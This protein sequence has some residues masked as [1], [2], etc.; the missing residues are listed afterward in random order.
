MGNIAVKPRASSSRR[1][2]RLPPPANYPIL[3]GTLGGLVLRPWFDSIAL[4]SVARLVLPLGRGWAAAVE[5]RGSEA[6]FTAALGQ[7]IGPA[8]LVRHALTRID[9]QARAYEAVAA[10]WERG[11]FSEVPAS[12]AELVRL[13]RARQAAAQ[14]HMVSR[15]ALLPFC[16]RLPAVRW[17]LPD[18]ATVVEKHGARL[19]G[20]AFPAPELPKIETSHKVP[21]SYGHESWLRFTSPV[22]ADRAWAR[23]FTPAGAKDPPTLI[24]LHGIALEPEMWRDQADPVAELA[25]RGLR[26]IRAEGPWHGRRRL[27]G[28]SAGEPALGRNPLGFLDLFQAWVSEVAVM[29]DWARR[30]SAGPVAVGGVS[31]GALTSQLVVSAA[32]GWPQSMQ[33]D[34]ALLVANTGNMLD[35]AFRGALSKALGVAA[36]LADA[37]W[38][39]EA[40][41]PWLP[42][43]EPAETPGLPPERIV[44]LLGRYDRVCPFVSGLGLAQRWALPAENVFVRRQGHFSLSLGIGRQPEPLRRLEAI[45]RGL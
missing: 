33:P 38:P 24:F 5:A 17:E 15:S 26:V 27:P 37:G 8:A 19:K 40:V 29:V 10:A 34:A 45:L 11:L 28:W 43:L 21:G 22:M 25:G 18:R 2:E 4:Q 23:V 31:L 36:R 30:T 20:Q 44:T 3:R 35:V 1:S 41:R 12:E 32:K 13:E 42:L 9:H 39:P 7:S 6:A 16:A 14:A